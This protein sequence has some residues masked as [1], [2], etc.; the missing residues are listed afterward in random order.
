V[1]A[2]QPSLADLVVAA[3]TTVDGV[4][5]MHA[6]MFGEVATY[7]P[8]RRVIGVQLRED[9]TNVHVILR[10]GVPLPDTVD[11]IRAALALVVNTPV[12]VT[13]EDV[14]TEPVARA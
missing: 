3:V 14:D 7:L 6:G 9:G 11:A 5:G 13:V 12:H 2:D 4:S 10:W 1:T 8:G